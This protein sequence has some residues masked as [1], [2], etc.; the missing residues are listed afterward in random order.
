MTS[1]SNSGKVRT[2]YKP[3]SLLGSTGKDSMAKLRKASGNEDSVVRLTPSA[4]ALRE[5]LFGKKPK[6]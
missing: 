4:L 6:S 5:G 3:A 2:L 1:S